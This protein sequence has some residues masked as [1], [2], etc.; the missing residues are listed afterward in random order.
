MNPQLNIVVILLVG[1]VSLGWAFMRTQRALHMLQLDSY[2]NDRLLLWLKAQPLRR[3]LELPS[4]LCHVAFLALAPVLPTTLVSPALLLACWV[5]CEAG[6]LLYAYFTAE[7]PKKPL[8]YTARARRILGT[9]LALSGGVMLVSA[10][11]A[12]ARLQPDFSAA[13]SVRA[14][15]AIL[16]VALLVIQLSS[17][18]TLLANVLLSPLQNA[19]NRTYLRRAE[20]R[21][22]EVKPSVIG[23]TGSYGKTSTKYLLEHLL[24]NHRRVLKTPLS[25]NTLMGICRVINENLNADCEVFIAEMG[26]YRRGDIKELCDFV[27]PT[28]GILTAIGPQHLERFKTIDNVQATKYELIEALP[29]SGVAIFN[30]DD[31]R[32][33]ALADRTTHVRVLRYGLETNGQSLDLWAEHI[34]MGSEGLSFTMAGKDGGR[35]AVRT[36]L[37]GRHNVLNILGAS[38]AALAIGIPLQELAKAIHDLP[39]VPHRLQLMDNGSGVTVIDDSYN[40]NPIGA[41]AALDVL[42]SFD[43]GQRILVTPGMVELGALETQLNEELGAKAAEVCDYVVLVGVERTKHL[44][45]GLQRKNFPPEKIRVVRDL[46]GATIVLPTIVGV[47]DTVLFENDLPDQ[48]T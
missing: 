14:A 10:W 41:M 20:K 28:V 30:N 43:R 37:L 2:A 36:M 22:R 5:V 4:G 7:Q 11:L 12:L 19:I 3:L 1:A 31:I 42:G 16:L 47:G 29:P 8:V 45:A 26:A 13:L 25:Y 39:P 15:V 35:V 24:A 34:A 40:S 6:V 33:R 9:S 17:L 46:N 27:H 44:V 18:M 32:C 38:C 21:L 48:Y 23:I